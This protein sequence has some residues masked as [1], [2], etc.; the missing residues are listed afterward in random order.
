VENKLTGF[1]IRSGEKIMFNLKRPYSEKAYKSWAFFG[2]MDYQESFCHKTGRES[3][4][5]TSMRKPML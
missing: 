5:K 4:G 2:N 1:Y 3:K